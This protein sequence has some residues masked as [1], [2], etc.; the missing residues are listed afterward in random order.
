MFK[1]PKNENS[2]IKNDE[3][4]INTKSFKNKDLEKSIVKLGLSINKEIKK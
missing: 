3:I 2:E 1:N 4:K